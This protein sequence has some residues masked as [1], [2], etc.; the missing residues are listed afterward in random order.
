MAEE[1]TDLKKLYDESKQQFDNDEIKR[2]M[3]EIHAEAYDKIR[4]PR[5]VVE[6]PNRDKSQLKKDAVEILNRKI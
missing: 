2:V 5:I 1:E 6:K 4:P 3:K